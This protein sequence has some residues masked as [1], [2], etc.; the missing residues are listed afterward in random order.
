MIS[1]DVQLAINIKMLPNAIWSGGASSVCNHCQEISG[2]FILQHAFN[3]IFMTV[4]DKSGLREA[5]AIQRI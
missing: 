1:S 5:K 4:T 2:Y 3:S